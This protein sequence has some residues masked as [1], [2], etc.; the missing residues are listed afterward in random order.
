MVVRL[1]S[2]KARHEQASID[3]FLRCTNDW[4][5]VYQFAQAASSLPPEPTTAQS[6]PSQG[7]P[8]K[9]RHAIRVRCSNQ[10]APRTLVGA[11]SAFLPWP[12]S[13]PRASVATS[14]VVVCCKHRGVFWVGG[15][16]RNSPCRR[17]RATPD[18]EILASRKRGIERDSSIQRPDEG[19]LEPRVRSLAFNRPC[20]RGCSPLDGSL[21]IATWPCRDR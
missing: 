12:F 18:L 21:V 3:V 14:R 8:A 11:R 16:H 5:P 9:I 7:E 1:C 6:I 19:M 2:K 17:S 10:S 20:P 15:A 13:Q 4:P